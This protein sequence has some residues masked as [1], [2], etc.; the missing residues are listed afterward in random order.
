[1]RPG[2]S[3]RWWPGSCVVIVAASS[4]SVLILDA[5]RRHSESG[6][7]L[8][9]DFGYRVPLLR[10]LTGQ[11]GSSTLVE[12]GPEHRASPKRGPAMSVSITVSRPEPGSAD[13]G[14]GSLVLLAAPGHPAHDPTAAA[15]LL[16][17]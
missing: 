4:D 9:C 12:S 17:S 1:M 7:P 11:T 13:A 10:S 16:A 14:D 8:A 15:C 5:V 6:D 3:V 2:P